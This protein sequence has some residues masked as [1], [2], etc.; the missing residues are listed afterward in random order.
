M[1][2]SVNRN[3]DEDFMLAKHSWELKERPYIYLHL[4]GAQRG[5]VNASC[6]PGPLKYYTIPQIPIYYR[7]RISRL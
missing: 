7:L 4:D 3:T 5:L 6:G 2:F 1:S